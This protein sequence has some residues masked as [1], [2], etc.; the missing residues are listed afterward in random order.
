MKCVYKISCKDKEI[1]EF[2][3]GSSVDFEHRKESHKSDSKN[4]NNKA[5]LNFVKLI[6]T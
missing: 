2:Y 1:T 4:L 6:N 5:L 3:I